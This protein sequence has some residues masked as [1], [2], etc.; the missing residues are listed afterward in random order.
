MPWIIKK[1]INIIFYHVTIFRRFRVNTMTSLKTQDKAL[2]SSLERKLKSEKES[3]LNVETQLKETKK[4]SNKSDVEN[5][6]TLRADNHDACLSRLQEL[7]YELKVVQG[8]HEETM[9]NIA[10]MNKENSELKRKNSENERE[11]MKKDVEY[12]TSALNLMQGK[13]L[14]LESSLSSETRLKLDLF[15][16]LGDARRQLEIVQSQMKGKCN[17]VDLLKAKIAEVMAVMPP[18]YHSSLQSF[19]SQT[20]SSTFLKT[21]PVDT[22]V[23]T[24]GYS[25]SPLAVTGK[26][27]GLT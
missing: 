7:E 22:V 10:E 14:H 24:V 4:R 8:K 2:I 26:N 19:V 9:L 18:Q 12:L 6:S 16:A 25:Q 5:I 13:N 23:T 3:R 21:P 11:K 17:E 27:P 1:K 20:D 15:S